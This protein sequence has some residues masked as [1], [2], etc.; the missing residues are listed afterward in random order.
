MFTLIDVAILVPLVTSLVLVILFTEVPAFGHWLGKEISKWKLRDRD[1]TKVKEAGIMV[2]H[3]VGRHRM[4]Y[5]EVSKLGLPILRA[6][7][8]GL[9]EDYNIHGH[10]PDFVPPEELQA[11]SSPPVSL[12]EM[13]HEGQIRGL[14]RMLGI[15]PDLLGSDRGGSTAAEVAHSSG[16]SV[17]VSP[18]EG[19]VHPPAGYQA[20]LRLATYVPSNAVRCCVNCRYTG[21]CDSGGLHPHRTVCDLWVDMPSTELQARAQAIAMDMGA[22]FADTGRRM[23]DQRAEVIRT[24][25]P[26]VMVTQR[27]MVGR[28]ERA[29][30]E[31]STE[32]HACDTCGTSGC[33]MRG[34]PVDHSE[35]TVWTRRLR[36]PAS[37]TESQVKICENCGACD[38]TAR[39]A[40]ISRKALPWTCWIPKP[41]TE[42]PCECRTN[43]DVSDIDERLE[44]ILQDN[45]SFS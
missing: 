17:L 14:T 20:S 28:Q 7:Y 4:P 1:A 35:C 29:T 31:A 36:S 10:I 25:V 8:E 19:A 18:L 26:L 39:G 6:L 15:P 3:L 41:I 21:S 34:S 37:P 30:R 45:E 13:T 38:C 40:G 22:D 23:E 24:G 43:L 33:L 9:H 44:E 32:S 42:C 5:S 27:Q 11:L 16:S 2:A 12:I